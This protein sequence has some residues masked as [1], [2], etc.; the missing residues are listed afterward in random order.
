MVD[1][2]TCHAVNSYKPSMRRFARVAAMFK[3]PAQRMPYRLPVVFVRVVPD[4]GVTKR[5]PLPP[6]PTMSRVMKQRLTLKIGNYLGN[7]DDKKHLNEAMFSV[8]APRYDLITRLFSFWQDASWKRGLMKALPA[9]SQPSCLDL[10]CGT[11]DLCFLLAEKYPDAT[12]LGVDLTPDMLTLARKAN[13]FNHVTFEK[14][15]MG[16][17]QAREA[18]YDIVTGGY[19]LRNAPDLAQTIAE[20]HRVLKPGG[21][22]AFLDFSKPTGRFAQ[23][24]EYTLLKGWTG[25]WGWILHR[26]HEVYSYIAE[27]LALYPDREQLQAMFI[28][29]GFTVKVSKLHFLGIT[30]TLLVAKHGSQ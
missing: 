14:G 13:R 29:Q 17:L 4:S 20:I 19:A 16:E 22:A 9:L 26:N 23:R 5:L 18:H 1:V 8:I 15:D 21:T 24:V 2:S 7:A 30:E 25:M 11:G 6:L 27:S 3:L 10:A 12:I 28:A